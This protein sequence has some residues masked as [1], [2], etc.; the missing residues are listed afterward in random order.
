MLCFGSAPTRRMD[1]RLPLGVTRW[2]VP[3]TTIHGFSSLVPEAGKKA[4]DEHK[5]HGRR[6]LAVCQGLAALRFSRF[7]G[8]STRSRRCRI[9]PRLPGEHVRFWAPPSPI[10]MLNIVSEGRDPRRGE[11]NTRP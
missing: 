1:L 7:S 10:A 4:C 6:R 11:V 2:E 3:P 5:N 9:R 8:S